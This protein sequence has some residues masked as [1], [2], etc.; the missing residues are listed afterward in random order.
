VT[1]F[2]VTLERHGAW[3]WTR[4]LRDQDG[5]DEHAAFMD[6]ITAAGFVVLGGPLESGREVLLIVEAPDEAAIG[7]TL[8]EDPWH[9][10]HLRIARISRWDLL[11]RGPEA[12]RIGPR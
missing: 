12:D 7:R 1:T 2:A 9:P 4:G 5:W 11:L 10:S 6:V 8:A 3:D